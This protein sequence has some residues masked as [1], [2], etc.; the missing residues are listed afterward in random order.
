[1]IKKEDI[2]EYTVGPVDGHSLTNSYPRRLSPSNYNNIWPTMESIATVLLSEILSD[3]QLATFLT[4][5]VRQGAWAAPRFIPGLDTAGVPL[6]VSNHAELMAWLLHLTAR[7]LYDP[8]VTT[9]IGEAAFTAIVE[10]YHKHSED[11]G[12]VEAHGLLIDCTPVNR[13][14]TAMA[15]WWWLQW[16]NTPPGARRVHNRSH[17]VHGFRSR[18]VEEA[19]FSRQAEVATAPDEIL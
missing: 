7:V 8:E 12:G 14:T 16:S 10:D 19:Q 6:L 9:V 2:E 13:P 15:R 4:A 3:N 5:L 18:A 1:M 17:S 11:P